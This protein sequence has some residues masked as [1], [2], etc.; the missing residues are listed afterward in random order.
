MKFDTLEDSKK[1]EEG[2]WPVWN[3]QEKLEWL[4]HAKNY[5]V[6][7]VIGYEDGYTQFDTTDACLR[8]AQGH[9]VG[10]YHS[11]F[12][13][14]HIRW[15]GKSS[16]YITIPNQEGVMMRYYIEN[17]NVIQWKPYEKPMR[18]QYEPGIRRQGRPLVHKKVAAY[19]S[20]V[21]AKYCV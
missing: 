2:L 3:A 17:G 11:R 21:R 20:R 18:S 7:M 4:P 16:G 13:S 19:N 8:D 10:K 12:V 14:G 15:V 6:G 5:V 1:I 9:V